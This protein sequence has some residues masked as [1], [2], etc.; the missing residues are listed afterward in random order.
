MKSNKTHKPLKSVVIG[1]QRVSL[2]GLPH[3]AA[4]ITDE[5]IERARPLTRKEKQGLQVPVLGGSFD[6][7]SQSPEKFFS[8][9]SIRNLMTQ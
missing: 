8:S 3:V 5:K 4:I 1:R 9:P 7:E 6:P 2:A